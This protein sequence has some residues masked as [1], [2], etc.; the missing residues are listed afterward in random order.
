MIKLNFCQFLTNYCSLTVFLTN[1]LS[2]KY[3]VFKMN[4]AIMMIFLFHFVLLIAIHGLFI[5][6][7]YLIV[8]LEFD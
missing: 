3:L 1:R 6:Y 4:Y 7:L 8:S 2:F 5:N